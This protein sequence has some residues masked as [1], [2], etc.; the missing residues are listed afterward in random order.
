MQKHYFVLQTNENYVYTATSGFCEHC[1]STPI[2]SMYENYPF[3]YYSNPLD[4]ELKQ[5]DKTIYLCLECLGKICRT[6]KS[7]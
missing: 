7:K 1:A 3:K 5:N 2:E 6:S 4:F